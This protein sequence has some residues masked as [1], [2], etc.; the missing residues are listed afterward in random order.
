MN[1]QIPDE[2]RRDRPQKSSTVV[3]RPF[4]R[5]KRL[6]GT[7]PSSNSKVTSLRHHLQEARWGFKL[8]LL[9]TLVQRELESRYKGS[10]LGNLWPLLTQLSQLLIYTYVFSIVLK[11]RL[12]LSGVPAN[13]FVYGLWLFA[14]LLPWFAFTNGLSQ[15]ASAVVSQTNLVKK[16]VFPLSLLPLV[17]VCA[18]FV[19]S[20][21]GLMILV[22]FV[23][24]FTQQFHT[25]LLL[26]PLFCL[27]QLLLTSGLGYFAAA[28]TVFLRDIPQTLNVVLNLW[29]YL[30]PIVYPVSSIPEGIQG[31]IFWL[32]PLAALAEIYRDAIIVGQIQHW[33]EWAIAAAVASIVF[34][35]GLWSYRKLRPGFA[36]VL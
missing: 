9:K 20:T 7:I 8:E 36:D 2:S 14:G 17:P 25:T 12:E 10:V 21:L 29:F 5:K 15:A 1:A 32:N 3:V 16:V 22:I 33:G 18:A 24:I 31:W 6:R 27:P 35:G 30:T 13:N 34:L 26:M 23:A 19:E 28:L 11:V 4:V